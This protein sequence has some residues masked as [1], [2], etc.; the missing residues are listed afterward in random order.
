MIHMHT[1]R[2]HTHSL[3]LR[4]HLFTHTTWSSFAPDRRLAHS[5]AHAFVYHHRHCIK[6]Y[7][8]L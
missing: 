5:Q 4:M 2:P 8:I 7:P 6:L 3:Y 1:L